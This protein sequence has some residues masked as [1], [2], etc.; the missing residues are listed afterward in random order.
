LKSDVVI[1][2]QEVRTA[3][4]PEKIREAFG[5]DASR[6]RSTHSG[7]RQ[8]AKVA[9]AIISVDDA[10]QCLARQAL[11]AAREPETST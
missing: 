9:A 5:A 1:G 11:A 3:G 7:L 6:Q 8:L 2:K 10:R 4:I